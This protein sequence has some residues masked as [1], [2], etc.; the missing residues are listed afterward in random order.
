MINVVS[1][2]IEIK[3]TSEWHNRR[4]YKHCSLHHKILC[5]NATCQHCYKSNSHLHRGIPLSRRGIEG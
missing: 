3:S 4:C 5:H 2:P 1:D